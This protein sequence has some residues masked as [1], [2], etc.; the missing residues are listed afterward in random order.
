VPVVTELP[1]YLFS[2]LREGELAL[3]RGSGDGLEPIL[4]VAPTLL[5]RMDL[6]AACSA[7][8]QDLAPT[9]AGRPTDLVVRLA[10]GG[11]G[12]LGAR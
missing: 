2:V 6:I 3:Y 4:L 12:L 8:P 10:T 9:N 1:S 11:A 7:C 5:A